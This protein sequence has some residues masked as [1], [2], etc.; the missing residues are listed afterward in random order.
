ML[1]GQSKRYQ[2]QWASQ[3]YV[4]AELT[5]KGYLVAF[6]LGNAPKIDLMACSPKGADFLI[7][8]KG[9]ATKNFWLFGHVPQRGDLFYVFVYVPSKGGPPQFFVLTAKEAEDERERYREHIR[10]VKGSYRD[11]F[12]GMNWTAAHKYED[13]WHVLP[14]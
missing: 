2:T 8:V 5:R 1:G 10:A 3:F 12:G 6:T 13:H 7:Q 4:A 9:Q 11:D 14:E